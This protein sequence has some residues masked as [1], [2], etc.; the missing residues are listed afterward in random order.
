MS[1]C[2]PCYWIRLIKSLLSSPLLYS[3][4]FSPRPLF[5]L[6]F[7]SSFPPSSLSSSLSITVITANVYPEDFMIISITEACA[8]LINRI[9]H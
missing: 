3:P 6:L 4:L 8:L 9:S 5:S 7:S 1:S 2:G